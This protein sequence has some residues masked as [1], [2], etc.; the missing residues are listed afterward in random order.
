M[1]Y[2]KIKIKNINNLYDSDDEIMDIY[3]IN[4]NIYFKEYTRQSI[5]F[6]KIN[7]N[8]LAEKIDNL[9]KILIQ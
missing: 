5:N 8:D 9:D 6:Y 1:K 2:Q 7:S 3:Y 4:D